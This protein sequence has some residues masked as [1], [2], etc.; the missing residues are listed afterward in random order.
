MALFSLSALLHSFIF[1]PFVCGTFLS[2]SCLPLPWGQLTGMDAGLSPGSQDS[3]PCR[4]QGHHR[5]PGT[6]LGARV[7]QRK[8]EISAWECPCLGV[9]E[10]LPWQ[11]ASSVSRVG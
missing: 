11:R 8:A 6:S 2:P 3:G 4:D 7:C 9:C 1:F 5:V 10:L